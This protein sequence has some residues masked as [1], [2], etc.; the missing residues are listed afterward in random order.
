MQSNDIPQGQDYAV[1]LFLLPKDDNKA[2]RIRDRF[3]VDDAFW[4]KWIPNLKA[5]TTPICVTATEAPD[6]QPALALILKKSPMDALFEEVG[7]N[8]AEELQVPAYTCLY[9]SLDDQTLAEMQT[10]PQ[11]W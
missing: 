6:G 5:W 8:I 9:T 7:H 11:P 10:A 4:A 1:L 3:L 2:Q